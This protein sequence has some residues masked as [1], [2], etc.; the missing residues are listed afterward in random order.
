VAGALPL[1]WTGIAL[2]VA[3]VLVVV[4]VLF[5]RRQTAPAPT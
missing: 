1:F 3:L 2:L 4:S 5:A